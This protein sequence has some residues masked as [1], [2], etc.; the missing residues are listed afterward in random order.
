MLIIIIKAQT[1]SSIINIQKDKRTK[2]RTDR[3]RWFQRV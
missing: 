3:T 2:R 1:I